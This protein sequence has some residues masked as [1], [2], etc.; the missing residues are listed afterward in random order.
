MSFPLTPSQ[1][2]GP[3]LHIGF[4]W[5]NTTEL[6]GAGVSGERIII[7][8]RLLDANHEPVPDGVIEI[9]Q[10]NAHGKYAHPEDTSAR[11]SEPGFAGFG[12]CPTDAEGYFRFTTVKPGSVPGVDGKPQAPHIAVNVFARG[13]LKQLSTR[14]Y[15]LGDN[16]DTDFA[17]QQIPAERRTTL[18][19]RPL[20]GSNSTF[21]W[22]IVLGGGGDDETVFFDI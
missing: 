1:T 17:M 9:W 19:A 16:H 22:N 12:R 10:A 5:L 7:A 3:Y 21:E 8:G 13:L 15:F 2:V 4:D 14:I 20:A 18:L 6:A 11:P